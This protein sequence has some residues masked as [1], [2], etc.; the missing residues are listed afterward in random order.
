MLHFATEKGISPWTERRA[1][2]ECNRA[3][4]DMASGWARYRYVLFNEDVQNTGQ[5][6]SEV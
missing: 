3:V 4:L 2:K 1:M 5:E 6:D